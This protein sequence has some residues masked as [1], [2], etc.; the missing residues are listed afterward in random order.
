MKE[1]LA[2]VCVCVCVSVHTHT[3]GHTHTRTYTHTDIH[4]PVDRKASLLASLSPLRKGK[5]D[6]RKDNERSHPQPPADVWV[7]LVVAACECVSRPLGSVAFTRPL[8][9]LSLFPPLSLSLCLLSLSLSHSLCQS[10]CLYESVFSALAWFFFLSRRRFPSF[11]NGPFASVGVSQ[12]GGSCLYSVY[13]SLS[14]SSLSLS[15][16]VYLSA[17]A[18]HCLDSSSVCLCGPDIGFVCSSGQK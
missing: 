6:T 15:L 2:A 8:R 10:A 18:A 11:L 9:A 5:A 12:C 16:S 17:C 4:F 14:L 13:L 7:Q 1:K 3:H